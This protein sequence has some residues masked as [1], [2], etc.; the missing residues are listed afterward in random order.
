MIT[1]AQHQ[2]PD[3][4]GRF[5]AGAPGPAA[6]SEHVRVTGIGRWW[7]D[8]AVEPQAVAVSCADQ[9][10]L[11]G[12]PGALSPETLVPLAGHHIVAPASFLPVLGAAFG[13]IH[14]WERMVYLRRS[15]ATAPRPPR[16]VT[17]R[18]LAPGDAP[19]LAA[20]EPGLAWIHASWGGPAGLA[21][22]GVGWAAFH[23]AEILAVAC[24]YFLGSAYEDIACATVPGN[25]RRHLGLA[26]VTA[27]C[28]DIAS[29]G[30]RPSW[31]CSRDNRPSRLLAW[32]AG[33]RLEYEYV[34]Y[35]AGQPLSPYAP[36]VAA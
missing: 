28:E 2:L 9:A 19:A 16:G 23:G 17:V 24:T 18:R 4:G 36:D 11:S 6:L 31:T 3:L 22:S 25:R 26:C 15:P 10:V 20:I 14:P 34:H 12:N 7:A 30:H 32:S 33:F 21:S 27:L 8:R 13:R 29:R 1:L 35:A 5:P